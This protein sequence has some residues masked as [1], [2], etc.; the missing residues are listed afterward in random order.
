[1]PHPVQTIDLLFEVN[2]GVPKAIFFLFVTIV[3]IWYQ[4]V[5]SNVNTYGCGYLMPNDAELNEYQN[6]EIL[7]PLETL[8]V[9]SS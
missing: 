8:I 3:S 9:L 7:I 5:L 2:I 4:P 1:M 6:P